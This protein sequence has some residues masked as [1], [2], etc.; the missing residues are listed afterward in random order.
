M[1]EETQSALERRISIRHPLSQRSR[2][3]RGVRGQ[4]A[5]WCSGSSDIDGDV[6][7]VDNGSEG[8]PRRDSH[9]R[10]GPRSFTSHVVAT[11]AR[12]SPGSGAARR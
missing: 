4:C 12:I 9:G 2:D 8:R 10:R 3:D 5:K 11:A 1:I 6:I 7:V